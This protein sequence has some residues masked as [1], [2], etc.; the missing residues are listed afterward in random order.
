MGGIGGGGGERVGWV[1]LRY[2][3][4]LISRQLSI[5]VYNT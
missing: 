4:E 1:W 5:E 3:F 2:V